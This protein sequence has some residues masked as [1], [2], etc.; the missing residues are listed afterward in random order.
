MYEVG[1]IS[2]IDTQYDVQSTHRPDSVFDCEYPSEAESYS[3]PPSREPFTGHRTG[4]PVGNEY[5]G[6][7]FFSTIQAPSQE[8]IG[9]AHTV[10]F[11]LDGTVFDTNT[12][13]A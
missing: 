3:D 2:E 1:H 4:V 7:T 13:N 11:R 9:S 10:S 6:V 5:D 12:G 8:P